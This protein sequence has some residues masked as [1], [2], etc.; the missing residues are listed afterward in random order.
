MRVAP[1]RLAGVAGL[2][3]LIAS[4]GEQAQL[5]SALD[6]PEPVSLSTVEPGSVVRGADQLEIAVTYPGED[7]TRATSMR[8][9]LLRP[10]GTLTG[11]VVYDREQLAEP[12]LPPVQ[13][14]E[15]EHGVYTLLVEALVNDQ[16]I[17]SD[18]RQIFVLDEPPEIQR[19][20]IRPTSIGPQMQA[21]AIAEL[22]YSAETRPY[23]RW[24]LGDTL[25]GEGYLADG[26]DRVVLTPGPEGQGAFQ[27]DLEVYPWGPEEGATIDGSTT[28]GGSAEL[29][30]RDG[31]GPL[32]PG[33]RGEEPGRVLRSYS[34]DGTT[35]AWEDS[36]S[37]AAAEPAAARGDAVLDLAGGALGF[38]VMP[39]SELT[40]PIVEEPAAVRERFGIEAVLVELSL[41]DGDAQTLRWLVPLNASEPTVLPPAQLPAAG[42][43]AQPALLEREDKGLV[44]RMRPEDERSVFVDRVRVIGLTGAE[45]R[46]VLA[47]TWS[48]E[49]LRQAA[50]REWVS[51]A[52]L[53]AAP[54]DWPDAITELG[55][56]AAPAGLDRELAEGEL[57]ALAL[58]P[59]GAR[60]S[61]SF[62]TQE[63]DLIRGREN[64]TLRD[65]QSGLERTV[66]ADPA[67]VVALQVI[68]RA[69]GSARIAVGSGELELAVPARSIRVAADATNAEI[70]LLLLIEP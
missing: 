12:A 39:G 25:V 31:V 69:G 56:N 54:A 6:E 40:V 3:L 28:I 64:W 51:D 63:L 7:A 65:R 27:V 30:V 62:D 41:V 67:A 42:E 22:S 5:F 29:L 55:W 13:L 10:D 37:T 19:L 15:P 57:N 32:P 20:S 18:R 34:F 33:T 21:L 45:R 53:A 68:T 24:M 4:C 66:A 59:V 11:E 60:L 61:F 35:L 9:Q 46:Q 44:V 17:I 47:T 52:A 8:V 58:V 23:L 38:R 50:E 1:G 26:N 43:A 70:P 2:L 14:P 16:I 48:D 49:L 36:L